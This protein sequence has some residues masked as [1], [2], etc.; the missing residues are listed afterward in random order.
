[1]ANAEL[2]NKYRILADQ[3]REKARIRDDLAESAVA[4]EGRMK[5]AIQVNDKLSEDIQD[6]VAAAREEKNTQR[7][8]AER[9]AGLE[10]RVK[11]R[12]QEEKL[13][14]HSLRELHDQGLFI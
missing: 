3:Y 10:A 12:E 2:S 13:V 5:K 11:E 14:G 8:H 7:T 4:L 6:A 1:M 9:L